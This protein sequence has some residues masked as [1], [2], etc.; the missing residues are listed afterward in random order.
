MFFCA[1]GED[2]GDLCYTE[3]GGFFDGPLHVIELEYGEQEVK[4]KSGIGLEFFVKDEENFGFA[5]TGYL[6]AVKEAAGYDVEDLAGFGTED[7]GEVG[8]LISGEGSG[9][10]GPG[11]GDP[12]TASHGFGFWPSGLRIEGVVGIERD[13]LRRLVVEVDGDVGGLAT[14]PVFLG[15]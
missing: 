15:G 8:G 4:R 6:G 5:D 3:F 12:A 9:G 1:T 10:G 11:I 13:L 7:A 2:G 14:V